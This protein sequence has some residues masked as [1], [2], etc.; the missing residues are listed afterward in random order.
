MCYMQDDAGI[1]SRRGILI[2]RVATAICSTDCF[3][4]PLAWFVEHACNPCAYIIL[5][6]KTHWLDLFVGVCV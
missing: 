6:N 5:Y 1:C 4:I 2:W 3:Y